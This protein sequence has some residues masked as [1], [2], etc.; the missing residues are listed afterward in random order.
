MPIPLEVA[1]ASISYMELTGADI[2]YG[3]SGND[4][5]GGEQDDFLYGGGGVDK[6]Y[7]QA[8]DDTL[9]G[10][11]G[12]D[13]L[14]GGTGEDTFQINRGSGRSLITDYDSDADS[15][16]LLGGLT[17]SD[18]TFNYVGGDTKIKYGND[19][20]AIVENTIA[21]DITFI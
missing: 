13:T 2:L 15:V 14:Y 9:F 6:L 20:M 12:N 11:Q 8:G 19:L 7:G 21:E 5:Y 1:L 18:L 4:T 3:Q 16:E 17:E 10:G